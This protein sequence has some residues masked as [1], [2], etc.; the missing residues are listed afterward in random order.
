MF[1]FLFVDCVRSSQPLVVVV[2]TEPTMCFVFV[3]VGGGAVVVDFVSSSQPLVV[4]V[5]TKPTMCFADCHASHL[6]LPA[7]LLLL[8]SSSCNWSC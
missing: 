8:P 3:V 7:I 2:M 5:V 6:L 1:L 4:V